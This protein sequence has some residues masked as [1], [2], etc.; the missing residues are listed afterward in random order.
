MPF[1]TV[2]GL[3]SFVIFAIA[4]VT[5]YHN[6]NSYEPSKR[7]IYIIIGTVIIYVVTAMICGMDAKG[8]DTRSEEALNDT[9]TV[10]ELIFTPVNALIILSLLGNTFGKIKDQ[11][12]RN[13]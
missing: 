9:V 2:V 7:I 11:V 10:M 12:I 4:C 6:T 5:I 13:R 3:I 8:V 1:M